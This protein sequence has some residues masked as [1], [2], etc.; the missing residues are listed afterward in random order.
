M[1]DEEKNA[2]I[3]WS[4]ETLCK[5]AEP[6]L[7]GGIIDAMDRLAGVEEQNRTDQEG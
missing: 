6:A 7:V 3:V 5:E 4:L 1:T 2:Q